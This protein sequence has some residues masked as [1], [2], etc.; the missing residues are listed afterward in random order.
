[1]VELEPLQIP[2]LHP[3]PQL[4]PHP[5]PPPPLPP[6][7]QRHP[8]PG[9][10]PPLEWGM[11]QGKEEEVE[12]EVVHLVVLQ[13]AQW[14]RHRRR[15]PLQR[16]RPVADL[17]TDLVTLRRLPGATSRKNELTIRLAI[18]KVRCVFFIGLFVCLYIYVIVSFRIFSRGLATLEPAVSVGRSVGRSVGL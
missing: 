4:P 13:P 3:L 10:R 2:H 1:M 17:E 12:E 11:F 7:Q 15:L 8:H 9:Q 6:P 5:L 16:R 18:T 14:W